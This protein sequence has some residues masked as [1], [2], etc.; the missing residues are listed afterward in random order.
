MGLKIDDFRLISAMAC[1]FTGHKPKNK[2]K[3]VI[4]LS[5][6]VDPTRSTCRRD[7]LLIEKVS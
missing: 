4:S 7:S 2:P 1:S 6:G 3:P 5:E